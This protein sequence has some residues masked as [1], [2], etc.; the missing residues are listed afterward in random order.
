MPLKQKYIELNNVKVYCEYSLNNKPPLLLIHGVAA[1]IYTFNEL[2]PLLEEHFSIVAIDLPGFGMSEKSR[3]FVYSFKNYAEIVAGCIEHFKL[4]NVNIVGHSMGGQIALFT[5]K[6]F[7]EKVNKL[8]LLASSGYL[9]RANKAVIYCT[10]LPFFKYFIKREVNKKEVKEVLKNVFYDHSLITKGHVDE[11]GKPL[12]EEGFYIS[13]LRLLRHRE[14]DL[15]S[16][17]LKT[18]LAPIL[19]LWGEDDKVVSVQVGHRLVKDLPNAKLI[20]YEK[21][22]HLISEERP[23]EVFQQILS[24]VK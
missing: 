24:F 21:T 12:K 17:E 23:N 13:L 11:F 9:K 14:G 2:I 10:Y 16:E 6:L 18:I 20:T 3:S 5:A 8:V 15:S 7:P 1:T 22:G 4:K 19:L